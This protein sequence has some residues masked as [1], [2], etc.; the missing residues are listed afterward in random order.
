MQSEE[1]LVGIGA[2]APIP[3]RLLVPVAAQLFQLDKLRGGWSAVH[4]TKC[5]ENMFPCRSC[6]FPPVLQ[7]SSDQYSFIRSGSWLCVLTRGP[8]SHGISSLC[9]YSC[10]MVV[11]VIHTVLVK[12][13]HVNS[14]Q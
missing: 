10:Q 3:E 14:L 2:C 4:R 11:R 6:A 1:R 13:L 12:A 8:F 9:G 7:Y 5:I